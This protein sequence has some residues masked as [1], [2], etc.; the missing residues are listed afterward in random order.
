MNSYFKCFI[1]NK[2]TLG[3]D[4]AFEIILILG[5]VTLICLDLIRNKKTLGI[6][7]LLKSF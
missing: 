1:R 3:I 4:F 6:D 7:L 5:C 2:K